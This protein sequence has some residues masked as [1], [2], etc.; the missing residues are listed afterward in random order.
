MMRLSSRVR[1]LLS[2]APLGQCAGQYRFFCQKNRCGEIALHFTSRTTD[3]QGTVC[4]GDSSEW[5]PLVG[6]DLSGLVPEAVAAGRVQLKLGAA[7]PPAGA[8]TAL[9]AL[10][11]VITHTTEH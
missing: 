1:R 11:T 10:F 5:R 2:C 8:A 6:S 7:A 4:F 3:T 9:T